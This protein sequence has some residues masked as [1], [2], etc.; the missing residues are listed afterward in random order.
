MGSQYGSILS[1]NAR[2]ISPTTP[3]VTAH[4]WCSSWFSNPNLTYG[5]KASM[6]LMKFSPT[7]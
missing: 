2:Q 7:A 1:S 6:Y 4:T 5:M 3:T